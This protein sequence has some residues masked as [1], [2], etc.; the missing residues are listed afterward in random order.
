MSKILGCIRLIPKR[1]TVHVTQPAC[2]QEVNKFPLKKQVNSTTSPEYTM[3][4][5]VT[6]ISNRYI[7]STPPNSKLRVAQVPVKLS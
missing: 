1:R 3:V 5:S 7:S 6:E 2:L 4:K